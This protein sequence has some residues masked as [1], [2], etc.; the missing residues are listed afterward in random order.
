MKL[1]RRARGQSSRAG[2][3]AARRRAEGRERPGKAWE[4][5]TTSDGGA[6]P[7][8]GGEERQRDRDRCQRSAG[9]RS[10]GCVSGSGRRV[11]VYEFPI[12]RLAFLQNILF[13]QDLLQRHVVLLQQDVDGRLRVEPESP[14]HSPIFS[15]AIFPLCKNGPTLHRPTGAQKRP[16]W[17]ESGRARRE[18]RRP[19]RAAAWPTGKGG[20]RQD[21]WRT[22]REKPTAPSVLGGSRR[23]KKQS[24]E[25]EDAETAAAAGTRCARRSEAK[26][27]RAGQHGRLEAA[28]EDRSCTTVF[29]NRFKRFFPTFFRLAP[30]NVNLSVHL[31]VDH[32][33]RLLCHATVTQAQEAW[34]SLGIHRAASSE[35]HPQSRIPRAASSEPHPQSRIL[36]RLGRFSARIDTP[37]TSKAQR[38]DDWPG[39][40]AAASTRRHTR[41]PVRIGPARCG[42]DEPDNGVSMARPRQTRQCVTLRPSK[43]AGCCPPSGAGGTQRGGNA[44]Q[45]ANRG[46]RRWRRRS[47]RGPRS[48]SKSAWARPPRSPPTAA[49]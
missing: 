7:E 10:Q 42:H 39:E 47:R 16:R 35:P 32:M 14:E 11:Q 20:R 37:T 33:R 27:P 15:P 34:A 40:P 24:I 18:C 48:L 5:A 21:G 28:A 6:R 45:S 19:N 41:E 25:R 43:I 31:S 4:R 49:R 22:E 44:D 2:G 3:C 8:K 12:G 46:W 26:A 36:I 38:C 23:R 29:Q 30:L 17:H 9:T 1:C 13:V